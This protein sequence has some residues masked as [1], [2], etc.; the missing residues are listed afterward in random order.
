MRMLKILGQLIDLW[1]E[2][3]WGAVILIALKISIST[4][5]VLFLTGSLCWYALAIAALVGALMFFVILYVLLFSI[6]AK[7]KD[8]ARLIDEKNR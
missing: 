2:L 6:A 1:L 3:G 8:L 5:L 7:A 4:W